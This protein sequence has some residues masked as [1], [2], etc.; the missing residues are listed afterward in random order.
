MRLCVLLLALVAVVAFAVPVSAQCGAVCAQAAVAPVYSA[1]VV[2]AV[3]VP[4]AVP[5]VPLAVVQPVV[6]VQAYA[7]PVVAVQKVQAVKAVYAA[8][9]VQK[10]VVQQKRG[11]FGFRR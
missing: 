4:Y 7:A 2:Q 11:L 1:P 9:V 5:S 3:A 6:Q 8:P 10:V